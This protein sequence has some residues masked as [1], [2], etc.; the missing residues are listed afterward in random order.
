VH[1]LSSS[2][3]LSES[4]VETAA[5]SGS[6]GGVAPADETKEEQMTKL[7]QARNPNTPVKELSVL[8]RCSDNHAQ[9]EVARN[10][11]TP[12]EALIY[13]AELKQMGIWWAIIR[14]PNC[15]EPVRLWI[16][17]AEKGGYAGM[18]LKKFIAAMG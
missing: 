8:A 13:L 17:L 14:N 15:P 4:K 1:R 9:F 2:I 3:H 16:R 18:S 7:E 5:C 10:P 12:V 11:S 6:S